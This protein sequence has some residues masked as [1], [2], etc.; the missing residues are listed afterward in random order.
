MGHPVGVYELTAKNKVE[1]M[2]TKPKGVREFPKFKES[3]FFNGVMRNVK[4][5][6]KIVAIGREQYSLF[7]NHTGEKVENSTA[8][9]GVRQVVDKGQFTKLYIGS[10]KELFKLSPR[11]QA[12]Y[13]YLMEA[14]QM[15]D[16]QVYFSPERC[17]EETGYKTPKSLYEGIAEL[18]EKDFIARASD[19][20]FFFLN[21]QIAFN[22]NRLVQF[23]DWVV[24]G[25]DIHKALIEQEKE[26]AARTLAESQIEM[27]PDAT[28]DQKEAAE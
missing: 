27:F 20:N 6:N 13:G 8:F 4:T 26:E 21:P 23:K 7:S 14:Q 18:L 19:T 17:A 11:A 25:S 15:N 5:G 28:A 24:R 1:V 9:V 3:P 22:G 10:I 12:V 2:A 16:H